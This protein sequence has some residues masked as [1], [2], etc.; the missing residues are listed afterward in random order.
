LALA[1]IAIVGPVACATAIISS[2]LISFSVT[3]E[4]YWWS[5]KVAIA[6]ALIGSVGCI[7]FGPHSTISSS[8]QNALAFCTFWKSTGATIV[9]ITTVVLGTI[10][11][12]IIY[13]RKKLEGTNATGK[14]ASLV[15]LAFP[16]LAS[17]IG[18]VTATFTKITGMFF[19][20][21]WIYLRQ[22]LL[23]LLGI[24]LTWITLFL[25]SLFVTS[26]SVERFDGRYYLPTYNV[27]S[28]L[29]ITV[30]GGVAFHEFENLPTPH[31]IL[32]VFTFFTFYVFG[33]EI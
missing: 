1:P 32:Y 25:V 20:Q 5:D 9:V 16:M 4:E 12:I 17:I 29:F 18:A 26:W 19:T 11:T 8:L 6:L 15:A 24:S 2:L 7:W 13:N 33:V 3:G 31:I 23:S 30:S 22:H 10:C 21:G 28:A 27:M 14:H